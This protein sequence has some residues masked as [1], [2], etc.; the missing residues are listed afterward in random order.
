M[1]AVVLHVTDEELAD[2][3]RKG[4]DRFDEMWEGVIHMA[5]APFYDHQR[6]VMAV[7]MFLGGLCEQGGRGVLAIGI[8]VFNEASAAPDYRIPDFTF[9]RSGREHILARD[10]IRGGGPDAVIEI[11]SPD[12]ETYEK[13]PFFARLGVR[14]VLVIDRDTKQ[15]EVFRLAGTQYIAV[16][17]D[18]DGWLRS[19]TMRVRLSGTAGSL[20]I[21]DLDDRTARCEISPFGS[22]KL[23]GKR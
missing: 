22:Y 17:A 7:A 20:V 18:A 13:L 12:D 19:E 6:I 4:I 5:P 10:G 3:R 9:V 8:N 16:Q 1:K 2:R 23:K 15:P 21:E 14:E 11:R